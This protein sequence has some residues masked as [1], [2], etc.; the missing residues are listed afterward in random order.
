MRE[1]SNSSHVHGRTLRNEIRLEIACLVS[2]PILYPAQV[3]CIESCTR[4][5]EKDI[6]RLYWIEAV[7]LERVETWICDVRY[8]PLPSVGIP[9]Q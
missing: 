7:R 4:Q 2:G 1:K 8:E 6:E 5:E 9:E 3:S